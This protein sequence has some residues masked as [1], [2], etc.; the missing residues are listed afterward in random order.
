MPRDEVVEGARLGGTFTIG[1]GRS[2]LG[3]LTV[4]GT[5]TALYL[6]DDEFFH[7][8][9]DA[10]DCLH[11]VLHDR[12]MVTVLGSSVRSEL[13]MAI[14]AYHLA[15]GMGRE[16]AKPRPRV[17]PYVAAVLD[18]LEV[19]QRPSWTT[20]GLTLLDAV[21]PGTGDGIED[22][23]EELAAEVEDGGKGPDRA[24]VLLA[25]ADSRRAVAAFHVFAAR[26]RDE[27][28]ERL[29][30]LGQYAME[31]TETDR[32][33]MFGRMLERWDQPFSIAGWMEAEEADT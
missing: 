8:A 14:D 9:D 31:T 7:L 25:C 22:A 19:G 26:D 18:K 30:L 2:V 23:L 21:P 29:Q 16:V 27:V 17:S 28:P 6:H 13:S 15:L 11:G 4:S 33:V 20:T 12:T 1:K 32:C 24:G 5:D 3:E 10:A